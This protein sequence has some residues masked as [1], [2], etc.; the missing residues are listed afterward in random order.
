MR[1]A[2]TKKGVMQ[3]RRW[4]LM[5]A[6][7]VLFLVL[8]GGGWA[9]DYQVA[10]MN[11]YICGSNYG[12]AVSCSTSTNYIGDKTDYSAASGS[13]AQYYLTCQHRQS[14]CASAGTF[15][16][17]YVSHHGTTSEKFKVFVYATAKTDG[18]S[19]PDANDTLVGATAEATL[20]TDDG[21][22]FSEVGDV[23]GATTASGYY[24]ECVTCG[25]SAGCNMHRAASSGGTF[26][27]MNLGTSAKYTTAPSDLGEDG[28]TWSST[29]DRKRQ[30]YV[31][32]GP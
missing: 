28:Y 32:I 9:E 6:S 30:S 7:I 17:A 23:G 24:W 22:G 13:V 20:S 31:T 11:P 15:G 16:K 8:A 1:A 10:R 29:A 3:V 18:S 4:A 21:S 19:E 26:W 14:N 2:I 25:T 27:T 12:A 5:T